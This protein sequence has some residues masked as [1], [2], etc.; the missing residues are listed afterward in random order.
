MSFWR[1]V[2]RNLQRHMFQSMLTT[3]GIVLGVGVWIFFAALSQGIRHNVLHNIVPDK[4]LEVVPQSVQLGG[5]KRQGGLFGGGESGL[6][7]YTVDDL[8]ALDHVVAAYPKQQMS[9]PATVHGGASLIGENVWSEFVADG[10][11]PDMVNLKPTQPA[12]A[13]RD[14]TTA[15]SCQNAEDC[16]TGATCENQQCVRP[17]C[18]PK[19]EVLWGEAAAQLQPEA[20]MIQAQFGRQ[21]RTSLRRFQ[22]DEHTRWAL[23][24]D[25]ND[26]AVRTWLRQQ[27][28]QGEHPKPSECPQDSYCDAVSRRCE[29]PVPVLASP[30]LLNLYNNGVY[31]ILRGTNIK[32]APPQ[33]SEELLIGFTVRAHLGEGMLGRSIRVA[34]GTQSTRS[35]PLR[36]VGFS[37]LAIPIGATMPLSYIQRWNKE[38]GRETSADMFSSIVLELDDAS[39]INATIDTIEQDLH[40]DIAQQYKGAQKASGMLTILLL[41]FGLLAGGVVLVGG[42]H[43]AQA[44]ALRNQV[45]RREFG[46]MR[47]MGASA[48]DILWMLV[49]EGAILGAIAGLLAFPLAYGAAALANSLFS[50]FVPAFPFKPDHLFIFSWWWWLWG[51]AIGVG[52]SVIGSFIPALRSARLDPADALRSHG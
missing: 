48:R 9:F 20:Q 25:K 8:L 42:L 11:D 21:V 31:S 52:A 1:I 50:H 16:G 41:V 23:V 24:V 47:C 37:P 34:E 46:M 33:L 32:K 28:A 12:Y 29:A 36:L 14:W 26:D 17:R 39:A 6:N 7:A 5:L 43:I 38:F 22:S 45:R 44:T 27:N 51:I 2:M 40:L 3:M 49:V 35:V 19:D 30:G 18:T 4:T 10:I 13:F 15:A